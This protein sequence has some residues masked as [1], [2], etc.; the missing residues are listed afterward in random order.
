MKLYFKMVIGGF[1]GLALMIFIGGVIPYLVSQ[2]SDEQVFL[3]I[4]LLILI[5]PGVLIYV[6][7]NMSRIESLLN[8]W[9]Q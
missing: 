3:G 5:V 9:M 7:K 8:R 2:A 6:Q 4:A 1:V